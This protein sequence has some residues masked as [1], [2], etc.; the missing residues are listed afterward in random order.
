M[1][2]Y[3]LFRSRPTRMTGP[4]YGRLFHVARPAT[5]GRSGVARCRLAA[6]KH[7]LL[8]SLA[9]LVWVGLVSVTG[10]SVPSAGAQDAGGEFLATV[11]IPQPVLASGM[12]LAPGIYG[13]RLDQERV[14]ALAGQSPE[15][16]RRIEIIQDGRVVGREVAE[17]LRDDDLPEVG[18]SSRPV[19]DGT[20]V[21]LLRGGEF[22]RVSIKQGQVRYLIH[23]PVAR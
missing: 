10:V 22:L 15:A 13:L 18:A 21:A 9:S 20:Q 1:S 23:F 8:P 11:Q 4:R 7:S 2:C 6:A 12:P 19:P 14:P 17:V 3:E 5:E 16:Q